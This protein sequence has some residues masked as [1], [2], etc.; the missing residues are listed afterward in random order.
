MSSGEHWEGEQPDGP[1]HLPGL[2]PGEP[3]R[4]LGLDL[5]SRRIGV[6]I[7]DDGRRVAS[8]IS[9]VQ[10]RGSHAE[11]HIELA[12]LVGRT[13]ANLVVVGLPLSL[14]GSRGPAATAVAAEVSELRLLLEVPV[15]VCDERYSTV[16]A[17]QA[18][19]AGGRRPA[20][21]RDLIDKTAAATILQTW[22]DRQRS[23]QLAS[24]HLPPGSDGAE[25]SSRSRPARRAH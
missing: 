14:N 7:S 8:A 15:E 4:V 21:R 10:R 16:V 2:E 11:D 19:A 9:M 13:G 23:R 5:G 1:P 17:R 25:H 12:S 22:L 20:A 24:P 6:A 3:G 18:L